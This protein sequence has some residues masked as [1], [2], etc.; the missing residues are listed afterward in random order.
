[1]TE[2]Q[3]NELFTT[4]ASLV[5]GVNVI[6]SDVKEIKETLNDHSRTMN[7]H[8]QTL[9]LLNSKIDTI[10]DTVITNDRRLTAVEKSAADL[11]DRAS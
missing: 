1:M 4:L 8:S 9:S 5:S 6:Q 2:N 10:A 11:Q 3:E 7:E